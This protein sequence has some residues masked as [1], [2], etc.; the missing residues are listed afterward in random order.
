MLITSGIGLVVN[1][2][3]GLTLHQSHTHSHGI[4]GGHNHG[5]GHSHSAPRNKRFQPGDVEN[6]TPVS[7]G[8]PPASDDSSCSS[9]S[10]AQV[11]ISK[12]PNI[13]VRAAYIHVI[14][15]FLQS[16]GVFAAALVIYFQPKLTIIDPIC[17]FIFSILVMGTTFAIIKDALV[18]LMEGAPKGIDFNDVRETL[19][20]VRGVCKVHNLRIWS[21]SM[22]K[23]AMSCHLAVEPASHSTNSILRKSSQLVK[24]R[25]GFCEVTIQIED[26]HES[27]QD[28][29]KCEEPR[30]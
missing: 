16:V 18:V 28:C 22:D 5:H 10:S 27:M 1:V 13:N 15:D 4:G 29:R 23:I 21:L 17:T 2:I 8:S 11:S 12:P 20:G 9:S 26:F 30:H 25:Y 19:L 6:G 24:S 3:M 7:N 14:G